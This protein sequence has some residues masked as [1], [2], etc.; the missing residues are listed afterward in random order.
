MRV[1]VRHTS[2]RRTIRSNL[3][4][5]R[6]NAVA[7]IAAAA[8]TPCILAACASAPAHPH[9]SAATTRTAVPQSPATSATAPATEPAVTP[10]SPP[11]NLRTVNW[12]NAS[13]PGQFC[14]VQA[15]V[16]LEEG[17]AT[18][19]SSRWGNVEFIEYTEGSPVIYGNLGGNAGEVA[20][21]KVMCTNGGGMADS[22]LVY[23]YI[24]FTGARGKLTALG[25]ITPQKQP[26]GVNASL[27]SG[28]V[29]SQGT[30]TVH[31]AWYHQNDPTC[32]PTGRATTVWTY[33]NGKL[34]PGTPDIAA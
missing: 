23:S 31:E 27:L 13:I 1:N 20:A 29:I 28:L 17:K 6:R 26:S 22:I 2:L 9:Q 16:S 12:S 14:Y 7:R 24:I 4:L 5:G 33:A 3:F 10:S 11:L 30:I 18:A 8:L 25:A 19:L 32:C 34:T 21:V 15:T